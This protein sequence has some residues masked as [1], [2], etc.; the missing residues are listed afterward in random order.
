MYQKW[1]TGGL[2]EAPAAKGKLTITH[3]NTLE[4]ASRCYR[5]NPTHL[6]PFARVLAAKY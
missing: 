1:Q 2:E 5:N 6:L 4:L 3:G